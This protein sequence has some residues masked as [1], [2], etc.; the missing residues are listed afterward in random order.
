MDKKQIEKDGSQE[1]QSVIEYIILMAVIIAL[2][3]VFLGPGGYFEEVYNRTIQQ[4]G[5][6]MLNAAITLFN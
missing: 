2:L 6:D 5:D 4:Q 3:I 1:G